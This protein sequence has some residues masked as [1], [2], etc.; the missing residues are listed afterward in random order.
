MGVWK[1]LKGKVIQDVGVRKEKA[2]LDITIGHNDLTFLE[3][4]I[5]KFIEAP[6]IIQQLKRLCPAQNDDFIVPSFKE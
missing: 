5:D 6:S 4:P 3:D 2:E 1:T